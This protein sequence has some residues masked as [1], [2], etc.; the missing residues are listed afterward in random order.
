MDKGIFTAVTSINSEKRREINNVHHLSNVSTIGF[1]KAFQASIDTIR[2]DGPGNKTRFMASSSETGLVDMTPGPKMF[3][4]NPLDIYMD[5]DTVLG[6]FNREG[7]YR[8]QYCPCAITGMRS[9]CLK[10]GCR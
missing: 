4:G 1:K 3:T 10:S 8:I 5:L 6:V 9:Q 2:V 7:N